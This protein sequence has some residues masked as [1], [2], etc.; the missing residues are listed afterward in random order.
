MKNRLHPVLAIY[1]IFQ[2]KSLHSSSLLL[3][4]RIQQ[5]I[6]VGSGLDIGHFKIGSFL[7]EQI[8]GFF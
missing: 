3:C 2:G 5:M 1:T 6:I 8:I 7:D 4:I